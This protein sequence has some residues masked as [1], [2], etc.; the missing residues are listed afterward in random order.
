MISLQS[1]NERDVVKVLLLVESVVTVLA[2][3]NQ[4]L[5]GVL[6][7]LIQ[8]RVGSGAVVTCGFDVCNVANRNR[9][10]VVGLVGN[11]VY[12]AVRSRTPSRRSS[13]EEL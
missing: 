5:I 13:P 4:I 11:Q 7:A 9:R 3:Q 2:E 6:L 8:Q 10:V 1:C 12:A